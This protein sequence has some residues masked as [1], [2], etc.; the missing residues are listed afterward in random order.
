MVVSWQLTVSFAW[1]GKA[2]TAS[3]QHYFESNYDVVA[4]ELVNND[5]DIQTKG[6]YP[7]QNGNDTPTAEARHTNLLN[8]T[9]EELPRVINNTADNTTEPILYQLS[10]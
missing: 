8:L 10:V 2:K 4:N 3:T 6:V 9:D 7:S 5:N 1:L